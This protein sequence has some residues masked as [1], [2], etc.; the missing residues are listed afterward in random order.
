MLSILKE[1]TFQKELQNIMANNVFYKK[2][3]VQT[4][5]QQQQN[6]NS[7]IKMFARAENRTRYLQHPSQMRYLWTTESAES[8][9]CCQD[10]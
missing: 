9:D 4:Q 1:L 6:T 10:S 8:I 5:Q 2:K 7:N 3:Q